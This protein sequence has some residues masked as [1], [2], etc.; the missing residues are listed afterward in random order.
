MT[1]TKTQERIEGAKNYQDYEALES[2]EC[3][4]ERMKEMHKMYHAMR[5]LI[6]REDFS[7]VELQH[8]IK[9]MRDLLD[10]LDF[11]ANQLYIKRSISG[12]LSTVNGWM[13]EEQEEA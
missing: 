7:T 5:N 3:I 4:K 13:N 9:M 1:M 12:V 2:I 6:D 8:D 11:N 10:R